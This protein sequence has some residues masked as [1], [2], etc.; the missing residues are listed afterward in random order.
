[1]MLEVLRREVCALHAEL[2]RNNLVA[3][4]RGNSR[5]REPATNL[6]VI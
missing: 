6:V 5:G 1:M 3:W 4:T 2:P